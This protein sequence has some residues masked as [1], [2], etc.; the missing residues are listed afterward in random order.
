V[1]VKLLKVFLQLLSILVFIY[2]LGSWFP[3]IR[4]SSFYWYL[5][6]VVEPFLNP[7]R[8]VIKPVNG[9]DFSPMILL[10]ILFLL[11]RVIR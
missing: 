7:I 9:V 2:A 8:K 3:R 5:S 10:F 11:Q 6:L 4:E 1:V